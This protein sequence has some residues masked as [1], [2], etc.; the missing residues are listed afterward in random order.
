[1][2]PA[3]ALVLGLSV[4]GV[5]LGGCSGPDSNALDAGATEDWTREEAVDPPLDNPLHAVPAGKQLPDLTKI[6]TLSDLLTYAA[7]NNPALEAAFNNWR[8]AL[9][10]VPQVKALPDPRFTYRYFIEE[11][12]TRVGAQRQSF[13]LA[14]TFPWLWKLKLRGDAA[15]EAANAAHQRYEA[16]KLKL[17]YQVKEAYYEYYYLYRAIAVTEENVK[18]LGHI[19]SVARTRY[20][21]GGASHPD[22][23]RAQVELGKL[24]DRL[25]SLR[26]LRGP[27]VARLNEVLNRPH[28]AP[29]PWVTEVQEEKISVTDELLFEWLK[30]YQP[31]LK[32]LQHEVER[33]KTEIDLAR[34]GYIPDVMLGVD[35]IDTAKS[36]GGR[37]PDDDGKDPVIASI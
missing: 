11:V 7:L 18:L 3:K 17:F 30:E 27:I 36:T 1:M 2:N 8:A 25:R 31:E 20:K 29:L 15:G 35:Y 26:E 14:Q 32:A 4:L 34:Q 28:G 23:I 37:D 9:E 19:E 6:A 10:R 21:V 12:E 24:G 22:V 33:N 5:L 13:G 16:V